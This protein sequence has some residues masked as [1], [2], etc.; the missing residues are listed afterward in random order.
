MLKYTPDKY[1]FMNIQLFLRT[2]HETFNNFNNSQNLM[3]T[4]RMTQSNVGELLSNC[5]QQQNKQKLKFLKAFTQSW[6]PS[7][8]SRQRLN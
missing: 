3:S 2:K 8:M 4:S 6:Q 5:F 7:S 1:Q